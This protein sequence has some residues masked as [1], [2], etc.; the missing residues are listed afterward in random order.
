MADDVFA[1]ILSRDNYTGQTIDLYRVVGLRERKSI[2]ANKAF[3]PGTNS[4]EGR[5]FAFTEQEVINYAMTDASKVAVVKAVIP[6]DILDKLDFSDNIDSK[7]FTNGVI[8]V[9]PEENELFNGSVIR[10][11]IKEW[12]GDWI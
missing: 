10:M 5:Q 3:L 6:K 11:E 1:I 8:T 12:I 4:L 2:L 9:Q 7:I